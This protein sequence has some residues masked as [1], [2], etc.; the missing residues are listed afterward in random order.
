M[1]PKREIL[2]GGIYGIK[3]IVVTARRRPKGCNH[4]CLYFCHCVLA[5][6]N[7]NYL[8]SQALEI[9]HWGERKEDFVKQNIHSKRGATNIMNTHCMLFQIRIAKH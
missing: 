7:S 6:Y 9:F 4:S 2:I 8:N 3:R 1:K 5:V